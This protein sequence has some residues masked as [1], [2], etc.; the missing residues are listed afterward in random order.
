MLQ[1]LLAQ[2][3][4][5]GRLEEAD[6]AKSTPALDTTSATDRTRK[7]VTLTEVRFRLSPCDSWFPSLECEI[8]PAPLATMR[9]AAIRSAVTISHQENEQK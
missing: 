5:Q 2:P 8:F 9:K 7:F 3:H 6:I 4:W 1:Q